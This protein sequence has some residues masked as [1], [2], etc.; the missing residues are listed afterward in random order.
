MAEPDSG[1]RR[2]AQSWDPARY[3]KNARF[4]AE[5]GEPLI[6]L[7]G[8]RPGERILDIGCGDGALTRKLAD[9]GA[10]V[11]GIDSAPEQVRA[12]RALGLDARVADGQALSFDREFDG[13]LSNAALHWMKR[14][15]DAIDGMWR[16]LRSG[17]RIAAEMGG[18]GNVGTI[19]AAL[20]AGLDRRGID[21]TSA[22]PWYFPAPDE[23]RRRL[24]RAGFEVRTV[25]LRPRPTRLP[26]DLAD[27]LSTFGEPFLASV[28]A[29]ERGIL[30]D[31]VAKAA[32]PA[33][34]RADGSWTADYVRLR[35]FAVK[36]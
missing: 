21:A 23:Y 17:G 4:V 10:R 24:E 3:A 9:T 30:I 22:D 5:L 11:T 12:A 7:L 27:W 1:A 2:P 19:H 25:E 8:P 6:A 28:P 20:A 26:G 33:L 34:R 13:I 16:A 36:P 15:D 32:A 18:R 31:E 14:P 35:F 29:S